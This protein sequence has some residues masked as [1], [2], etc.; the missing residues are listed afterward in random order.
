MMVVPFL[1]MEKTGM[2]VII[3]VQQIFLVLPSSC[4]PFGGV[5]P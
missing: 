5:W 3:G 1:E 2:V 4:P